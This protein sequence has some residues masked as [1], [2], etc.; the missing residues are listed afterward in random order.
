[1]IHRQL[2]IGAPAKQGALEL[3]VAPTVAAQISLA[4]PT[5]YFV[6]PVQSASELR[7]AAQL[8]ASGSWCCASV[9]WSVADLIR[10][11]LVV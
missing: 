10:L 7:T 3:A 2:S 9:G 1:M 4:G 8:R 11:E 6:C 5:N